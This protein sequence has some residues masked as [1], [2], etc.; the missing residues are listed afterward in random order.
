[1]SETA[2]FAKIAKNNPIVGYD[3]DEL[4]NKRRKALENCMEDAMRKVQEAQS[5]NTQSTMEMMDRHL[6]TVRKSQELNRER[7]RKQAIERLAQKRKEEHSEI[8]AEMA[9]RNAERRD[10]LE[11]ARLKK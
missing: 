1:M 8:L 3:L 9:I 7:A 6:E 10:L 2:G 5:A 4:C 11:A